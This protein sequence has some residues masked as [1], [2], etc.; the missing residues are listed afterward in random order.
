LLILRGLDLE[1]RGVALHLEVLVSVLD[2]MQ[3]LLSGLQQILMNQGVAICLLILGVHQVQG[4][5][6]LINT[7][8]LD[9]TIP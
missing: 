9:L 1:N 7:I 8:I 4:Q 6:H 3:P 5:W 2:R